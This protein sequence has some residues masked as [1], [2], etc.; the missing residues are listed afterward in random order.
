MPDKSTVLSP[1]PACRQLIVRDKSGD[2]RRGH[3]M[4]PSDEVR[5]VVRFEL[6]VSARLGGTAVK[7]GM[8]G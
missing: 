5:V 4:K 3:Q 1:G 7:E 6:F 2:G 8:K